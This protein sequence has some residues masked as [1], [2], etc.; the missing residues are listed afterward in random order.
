VKKSDYSFLIAFFAAL[1]LHAGIALFLRTNPLGAANPIPI[2][3][4][5]QPVTLRF[6]EVPPNTRAVPFTPNTNKL[7]DMNRVAGPLV[8][9]QQQARSARPASEGRRPQAPAAVQQQT[10]QAQQYQ[11]PLP[12]QPSQQQTP[13]DTNGDLSSPQQQARLSQSLNNLDQFIGKG[14]GS[15]G[16]GSGD[17]DATPDP[18]SGVYF[19]TRGFD[20]GPWANRVIAIVK[21]NWLIP[22]AADLGQKGVVGVAFEVDRSGNIMNVRVI[23]KSGVISFDQA[24]ANALKSSNPFPPLPADFPRQVLPGVFRFYYNTPVPD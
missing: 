17:A 1:I 12:A 13:P 8:K 7:S 21:S 9:P 3:P 4:S 10:P 18:G 5:K 11:P 6:V 20:L 19:D 15:N 2:T 16:T 23:S 24:A 14:N 22:V